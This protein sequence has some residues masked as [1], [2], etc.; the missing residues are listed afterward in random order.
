MKVNQKENKKKKNAKKENNMNNNLITIFFGIISIV[1][2]FIFK[3]IA[4]PFAIIGLIFSIKEQKDLKKINIGFIIN[5]VALILITFSIIFNYPKTIKKSSNQ[6][7][8]N[9]VVNQSE[10]KKY[11]LGTWSCSNQ[12]KLDEYTLL[13]TLNS[14]NTY[15]FSQY[16]NADNNYIIG[17]YEVSLHDS[18]S[19]QIMK[20]YSVYWFNLKLI[21]TDKYILDGKQIDQKYDASYDLGRIIRKEYTNKKIILSQANGSITYICDKK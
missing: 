1:F 19:L 11:F 12:L 15:K 20:D 2:I 13:I 14:D 17:K 4:L 18:K 16:N 7:N 6:S 9:K 8:K 3:W 10:I 5:I 21:D